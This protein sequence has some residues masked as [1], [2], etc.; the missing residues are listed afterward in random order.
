MLCVS[1]F[2]GAEPLTAVF[3]SEHDPQL[4]AYAESGLRIYFTGFLFAGVNMVT[5]AF[6]S[7]SDKTCLLYT[8]KLT[9][10]GK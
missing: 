5:A 3:N 9:E 2:L 10:V 7:A 4:A 1:V 8:S 6:F